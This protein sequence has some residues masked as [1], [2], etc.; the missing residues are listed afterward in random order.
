M[1]GIFSGIIY[2]I[3]LTYVNYIFFTFFVSSMLR[4]LTKVFIYEIITQVHFPFQL[5]QD[6]VINDRQ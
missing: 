3:I 2:C 4:Y 6:S 5:K 1:L